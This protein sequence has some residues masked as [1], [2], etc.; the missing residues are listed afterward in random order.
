VIARSVGAADEGVARIGGGRAGVLGAGSLDC[1]LLV[2]G[3]P[4]DA[5]AS[6]ALALA[7]GAACRA[8]FHLSG[9]LPAS[10]LAPL[11]AGGASLGSLHPVR[12]FS[13]DSGELWEGT[14]VA[15][16][17]EAVAVELG[18]KMAGA[19]GAHGHRLGAEAKPLYHAAAALAAGGSLAAV[20]LATRL[21][22]AIGI[23]E[24][25]ARS[26]LADLS[27]RASGAAV[28]R[29]FQEAF[30]GPVA[31]RDAGTVRAHRAALRGIP[32][33]LAAYRTMVREILERTPGRGKEDEIRAA[34][35]DD[36]R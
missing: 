17:G 20:S 16:E 6:T 3:V 24:D 11:A 22:S 19:L 21:W 33:A 18:E 7:P 12:P 34:L 15:I 26:A 25:L 36:D 29:S 30:T 9:A 27:A 35:E 4:D 13:G 32:E 1:D 5:I 14:F 23:P 28:S 10:L 8:A 2:I 31:R